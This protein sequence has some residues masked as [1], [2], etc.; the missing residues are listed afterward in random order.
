MILGAYRKECGRLPS[1]MSR[2]K[3]NIAQTSWLNLVLINQMLRWFDLSLHLG[4]GKVFLTTAVVFF[5]S[6]RFLF[7]FCT[8]KKKT[9]SR[10]EFTP[11]S[12]LVE[13]YT[14]WSPL[15]TKKSTCN[16]I[17]W[18]CAAEVIMVISLIRPCRK[19][20]SDCGVCCH[21]IMFLSFYRNLLRCILIFYCLISHYR[22]IIWS[23]QSRSDI[24]GKEKP[25]FWV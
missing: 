19:F 14:F 16:L 20:C 1:T 3:A 15:R 2:G 12:R 13:N 11:W 21:L 10:R 24:R 22:T 23:V 25:K 8:K 18:I 17:W 9:K 7:T 6:G 4:F 5:L